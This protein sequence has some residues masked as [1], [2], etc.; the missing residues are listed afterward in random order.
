MLSARIIC[1]LP[2]GR[3]R[4]I[5]GIGISRRRYRLFRLQNRPTAF[6]DALLAALFCLTLASPLLLADI[7]VQLSFGSVAGIALI[8]PTLNALWERPFSRTR[9]ITPSST[10]TAAG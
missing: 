2:F 4:R 7:G 10:S 3:H 6:P 8:A 9:T 1:V 5:C